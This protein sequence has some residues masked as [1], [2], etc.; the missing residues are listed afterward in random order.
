[1]AAGSMKGDRLLG[2]SFIECS[3][4]HHGML[5]CFI[6]IK[7]TTSCEYLTSSSQDGN[8]VITMYLLDKSSDGSK[9]DQM[10]FMYRTNI[11]NIMT[12]LTYLLQCSD[13]HGITVY[14]LYAVE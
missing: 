12:A 13:P 4:H 3:N 8:D 2:H 7:H 9:L 10:K 5:H 6:L 14:H 1:M 11:N